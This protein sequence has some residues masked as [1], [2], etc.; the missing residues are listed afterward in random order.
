MSDGSS[1]HISKY[2]AYLCHVQEY[3]LD[4]FIDVGSGRT[5]NFH[6]VEDDRIDPAELCKTTK[7]VQLQFVEI[8]ESDEGLEISQFTC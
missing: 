2:S 1:K 3:V 4:V 7:Q 5:E 8:L 6:G